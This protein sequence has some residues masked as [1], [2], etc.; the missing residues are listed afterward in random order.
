MDILN[1][2]VNVPSEPIAVGKILHLKQL[3]TLK[4]Q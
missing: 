1:V 2:K 4:P 3:P